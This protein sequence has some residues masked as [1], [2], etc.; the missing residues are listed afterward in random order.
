ML[1]VPVY[2]DTV[3]EKVQ[4]GFSKI[5]SKQEVVEYKFCEGTDHLKAALRSG[6]TSVQEFWLRMQ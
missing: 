1:H 2:M 5:A 4:C 6:M 3:H